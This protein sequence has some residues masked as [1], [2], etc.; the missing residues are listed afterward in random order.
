[1]SPGLGPG[2]DGGT[3]NSTSATLPAHSPSLNSSH[4]SGSLP[5]PLSPSPS[6][7]SDK[8]EQD[9]QVS[10]PPPAC[11]CCRFVLADLSFMSRDRQ[12]R[13]EEERKRRLQ[14][15]VFVSRCVAYPFNAKQPTDMTKR[16]LKVSKQQL[17][18]L[19]QRFQVKHTRSHFSFW[20]YTQGVNNWWFLNLFCLPRRGIKCRVWRMQSFLKGE[21]PIL[22]DEAF[23]NAVQSYT[24]LFLRS[25]R[26]LHAVTAGGLSS[27]DFRDVFRL[28]VERRVRSLPDI[29]G[30]SKETVLTSWMV[31][32]DAIFKGFF[33]FLFPFFISL[34]MIDERCAFLYNCGILSTFPRIKDESG[35]HGVCTHACLV[36]ITF[37][38]SWAQHCFSLTGYLI[39]RS[40]RLSLP[41]SIFSLFQ[42]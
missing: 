24:E 37:P 4:R 38:L 42:I 9:F 33:H 3:S 13:E 18:S 2:T 36:V 21:T 39:M 22:A 12:E 35:D 31:K 6:L 27:Q 40:G 23:H 15:Y 29:D 25:D 32:F 14:L 11:V 26:V 30:L 16:Q 8:N 41:R 10:L 28:S 7:T 5:R 34:K 1:M 19:Q 20:F 17:E